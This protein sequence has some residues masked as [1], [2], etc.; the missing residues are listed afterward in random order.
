MASS[1]LSALS[2]AY[3]AATGD[4]ET[5]FGTPERM[6]QFPLYDQQRSNAFNQILQMALQG[7]QNPTQGFQPIANEANRQFNT[8]TIPSLAERFTSMGTGGRLGNDSRQQSSAFAG[9]LGAAGSGLQQGLAALKSQYGLQNQ[10]NL[11][12]LLGIGLTPQFGQKQIPAS[13]GL[14]PQILGIL[15]GAAGAVGGPALAG[16]GYNLGSGLGNAASNTFQQSQQQQSMPGL[17]VNRLG[18]MGGQGMS[19]GMPNVGGTGSLMPF[20]QNSFMGFN[21]GY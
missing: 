10:G 1:F 9:A 17:S 3:A 8:Q 5:W 13:Q 6:E 20:M 7:L 12:N 11:L 16:V 18:G 14:L 4:S 2:P 19:G 21:R 15:G